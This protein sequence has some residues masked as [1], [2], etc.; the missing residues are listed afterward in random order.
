MR[1]KRAAAKRPSRKADSYL[2]REMGVALFSALSLLFCRAAGIIMLQPSNSTIVP[3]PQNCVITVSLAGGGGGGISNGAFPGA[4]GGSGSEIILKFP[5]SADCQ[6]IVGLGGGAAPH[7]DY[8]ELAF[9]GG[10]ASAI[11]CA[12][13]V[14][15]VAGGGGGG[16]FYVQL[17]SPTRPE[18]TYI[19]FGLRGGN[20]GGINLP[21]EAGGA[22]TAGL[23]GGGGPP[24]SAGFP[25]PGTGFCIG[26]SGDVNGG[27]GCTLSL[28]PGCTALA[29]VSGGDGWSSG[30]GASWAN[31]ANP[32]GGSM[33]VGGSG[34]GGGTDSHGGPGGGGGGST[35]SLSDPPSFQLAAG[36]GGGGGSYVDVS[37]VD[38]FSGQSAG[39]GGTSGPGGDGW[40][41]IYTCAPLPSASPASTSLTASLT[42][43]PTMSPTVSL[44]VS[45]TTS[46]TSAET[47]TPSPS[48]ASEAPCPP[49]RPADS[50]GYA[51]GLAGCA[52]GAL[53][54][55][56]QLLPV[57]ARWG[58]ALR[59]A[60]SGGG[61]GRYRAPSAGEALLLQ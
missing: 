7:P 50:A 15:A 2:S 47:A 19:Y 23:S 58:Q 3:L 52:M 31:C 35:F 21:G 24:G 26:T 28:F 41:N 45:Q 17:G 18:P 44:A 42:A 13:K 10:G 48:P 25:G 29:F 54:L 32:N 6:G 22:G 51:A 60:K 27:D 16:A 46:P 36:A 5:T 12:G 20:G 30:G 37:A 59:A 61:G 40:V 11:L 55:G 33:V 56:A 9:G 14:I 8:L 53:A 4:T 38:F 34:G 57:L 49:W 39:N 1:K 43:L